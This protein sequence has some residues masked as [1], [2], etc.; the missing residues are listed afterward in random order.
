MKSKIKR[1]PEQEYIEYDDSE[2][3]EEKEVKEELEIKE[4]IDMKEELEIQEDI[5]FTHSTH[6]LFIDQTSCGLLSYKHSILEFQFC[7]HKAHITS[8]L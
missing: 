1:E 8:E 3:K 5:V 7:P 2:I 4:E 6:Q